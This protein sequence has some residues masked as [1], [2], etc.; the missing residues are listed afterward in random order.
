MSFFEWTP[1]MSVG[2]A[3]LDDDHK[4]LISIINRL[5]E[6]IGKA[7]R[8]SVLDQAFRA[9]IRYTELHFGREE[10]VLSAVNYPALSGHHQQHRDFI[11][12]ILDLQK[13]LD[14]V[15]GSDTQQQLLE[16]LRNWL[17]HHI[18]VEDKAYVDSVANNPR[19]RQAAE[20]FSSIGMWTQR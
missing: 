8:K 7:D 1:D 20:K 11:D 4:V 18:L 15:G 12:E 16:Y 17:T 5:A 3:R 13:G 6:N 9:L 14:K 2:M 19:A 10:S